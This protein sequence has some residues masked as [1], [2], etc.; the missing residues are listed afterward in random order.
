MNARNL[1]WEV[2]CLKFFLW[3]P[4]L[5]LVLPIIKKQ[6]ITNVLGTEIHPKW[7]FYWNLFCKIFLHC[8]HLNEYCWY[9]NIMHPMEQNWVL[10]IFCET[11]IPET[12]TQTPNKT[13]QDFWLR[14][15]CFFF[16]FANK[17][18][19]NLGQNIPYG[20]CHN[21]T[22]NGQI[23]QQK[24]FPY[25]INFRNPTPRNVLSHWCCVSNFQ[26]LFAQ[27]ENVVL[28]FSCFPQK[29]ES[30]KPV[31]VLQGS[32]CYAD[33]SPKLLVENYNDVFVNPQ[34]TGVYL[35]HVN[36]CT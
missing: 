9:G 2:S 7:C 29:K 31:H 15:I 17:S 12:Y 4:Y 19:K 23:S 20:A 33:L 32:G 13:Q 22:W 8:L 1:F 21:V 36:I 18:I 24:G 27:L 28:L 35:F 3:R 30:I 26:F 5:M 11:I 25:H 16:F 14:G 34:V 6:S 10:Q